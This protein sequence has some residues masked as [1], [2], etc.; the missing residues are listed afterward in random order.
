MGYIGH[1]T[2]FYTLWLCCEI[3]MFSSKMRYI[4]VLEELMNSCMRLV[5]EFGIPMKF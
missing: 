3:L 4:N 5:I 1:K 2:V